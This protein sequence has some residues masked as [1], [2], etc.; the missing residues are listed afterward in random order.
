MAIADTITSMQNHTSNAYDMLEYGTDL[1][2]I[3]KNLENLSSTIFEA[4]LEALRNPDTL[5][6]NLPKTSGSGSNITLNGT[7]YAPMRITLNPTAISQT[8]YTGKNLLEPN[9]ETYN[10][11]GIK[12]SITNNGW[13]VDGTMESGYTSATFV[14]FEKQ[15][16]S[17]TYTINGI[18]GSSGSTYQARLYYNGDAQAYIKTTDY[19]FTIAEATTITKRLGG[20]LE[21]IKGLTLV[22]IWK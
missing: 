22:G 1:T 12:L 21:M 14:L 17:G 6:N 10:Y 19:T 15:L 5:F 11:R 7:A 18:S 4:F 3:N 20:N 9:V 13:L 16:P 8:T 2:G